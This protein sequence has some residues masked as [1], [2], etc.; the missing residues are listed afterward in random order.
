MN[1][2]LLYSWEIMIALK[3]LLMA[4]EI[5]WP[6]HSDE[7]KEKIWNFHEYSKW[8]S[9]DFEYYKH[10]TWRK[11]YAEVKKI[12]FIAGLF[13]FFAILSLT[14]CF[15]SEHIVKD[16]SSVVQEVSMNRIHLIFYKTM[17]VQFLEEDL[18]CQNPRKIQYLTKDKFA[19]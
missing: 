14:V 3:L 2:S 5:I 18:S 10:F 9:I 11:N 8:V 13:N 17:Y 6:L 16:F 19:T 12:H 1:S 4:K 15:L 7:F